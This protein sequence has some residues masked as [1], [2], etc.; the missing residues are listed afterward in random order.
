M[1]IGD[2]G[3]GWNGTKLSGLITGVA[4]GAGENAGCEPFTG[5]VGLI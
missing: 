3:A 2:G 1:A 5:A 4:V